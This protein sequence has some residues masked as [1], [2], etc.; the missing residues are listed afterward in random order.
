MI[1]T[2]D[3][4][5]LLVTIDL[6]ILAAALTLLAIYPAIVLSMEA[7]RNA[8]S[9]ANVVSHE[10]RRRALFRWLGF[11]AIAS[12]TALIMVL[13]DATG[14]VLNAKPTELVAICCQPSEAT[15]TSVE[16][17]LL[18]LAAIASLFSLISVGRAG[19]LIFQL[20]EEKA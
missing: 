7:S 19:F 17:W 16:K 12:F 8:T 10:H 4:I 20:T 9:A 11:A 1:E 3:F 15:L 14:F 6:G 2:K 13:I 18:R 5:S